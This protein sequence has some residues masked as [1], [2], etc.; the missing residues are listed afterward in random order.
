MV[1]KLLDELTRGGTLKMQEYGKAKV[2]YANQGALPNGAGDVSEGKMQKLEQDAKDFTSK[3]EAA[4]AQ[5]RE[6]QSR[7]N[8][9]SAQPS[10]SSLDEKL[11]STALDLERMEARNDAAKGQGRGN[12]AGGMKAAKASANKY[13]ALWLARKRN[14]MD[15]VDMIC[16]GMEKKPKVVM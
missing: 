9:L 5:A 8:S 2:Y 13:R 1:Q 3:L 7:A 12:V 15:V 16:D 10:D 11:A 4:S 14:A 6:A